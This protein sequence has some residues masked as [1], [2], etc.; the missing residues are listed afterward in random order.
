ME[1]PLD[2]LERKELNKL[3]EF[4]AGFTDEGVPTDSGDT[5]RLAKELEAVQKELAAKRRKVTAA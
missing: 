4:R 1:S 2:E 3:R 5:K